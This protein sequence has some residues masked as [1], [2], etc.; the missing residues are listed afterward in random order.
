MY[1]FEWFV[2][3]DMQDVELQMTFFFNSIE[4]KLEN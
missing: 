4:R 1:D 3:I 2:R